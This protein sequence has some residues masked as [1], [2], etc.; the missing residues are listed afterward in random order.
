MAAQGHGKASIARQ[1][2]VEGVATFGRANGW[3]ASYVL[4]I[5][6]NPAVIGHY[7]PHRNTYVDGKKTRV[8]EGE[9]I[10]RYFPAVVEPSLFY[11]VKHSRPGP[12]GK[13]DHL[14]RNVLSGLVFC[15]RC[16][17]KMHYVNK[18]RSHQYLAC[19]N[20][21]RFRSCDAPAAPYQS[22]LDSVLDR[23]KDFRDIEPDNSAVRERDRE[24]DALAGQIEETQEAIGRLIDTLERVQ[25]E[26]VEERLASLEAK[27]AALKAKRE[28]LREKKIS[29][30][31]R[32]PP[33]TVYITF[34]DTSPRILDSKNAARDLIA[35]IGAEIRRNVERVE[36]E[37]G[38]LV[39]VVPR[40][41]G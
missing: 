20:A 29:R 15:A 33:E 41:D 38:Q 4:K 36:V 7:Q 18:G 28:E 16:G 19:D 12:S 30:E 25:S 14:P 27:L 17:G 37:K 2:N 40:S 31:N 26:A 24:I 11:S 39:K 1:L 10:E 21:R 13:G 23:V 5:L 35:H 8:P 9:A 6:R 34:E 3:H 22:V 32:I